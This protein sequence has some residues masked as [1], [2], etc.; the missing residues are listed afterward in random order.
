MERRCRLRRPGEV[1]RV[2]DEGRSWSHPL[3]A[4]VARPNGSVCTRLG[5]TASRSVGTAVVRNRAR[6][7]M[8]EAA[9]HLRP[10]IKAGWD[11]MLVARTRIAGAKEP[12]VEAALAALLRQAGLAAW[13]DGAEEGQG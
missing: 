3:L 12:Q 2:Y 4:L 7:L 9:R 6:R 10:G 5:F 11:V 1:R 8:R 13:G